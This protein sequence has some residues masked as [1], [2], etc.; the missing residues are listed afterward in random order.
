MKEISN[1]Q[2]PQSQGLNFEGSK[3]TLLLVSKKKKRE[4]IKIKPANF[5]SKTWISFL[6]TPGFRQSLLSLLL[7]ELKDKPENLSLKDR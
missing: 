2:P 3:I 4:G 1:R 5:D 6:K 7:G